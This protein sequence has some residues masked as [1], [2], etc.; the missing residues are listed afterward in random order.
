VI[1]VG[2]GSAARE[3]EAKSTPATPADALSTSRLENRRLLIASSRCGS[4]LALIRGQTPNS[5][6]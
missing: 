5:L 3:G 2:S 4:D 6:L 1:V